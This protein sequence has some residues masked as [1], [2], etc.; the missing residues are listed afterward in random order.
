LYW[1]VNKHS[2]EACQQHGIW[3]PVYPDGSL[4]CIA[5]MDKFI[6]YYFEFEAI[7]FGTKEAYGEL[8][9]QHKIMLSEV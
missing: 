9:K 5:D 7:E 2:Q 3:F 1:C 4:Y 8:I 6:D